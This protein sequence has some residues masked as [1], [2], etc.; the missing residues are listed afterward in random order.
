M[1]QKGFTSL[2]VILI[3]LVFLSASAFLLL[4]VPSKNKESIQSSPTQSETRKAE[5]PQIV[6]NSG[7]PPLKLKSIGINLDYYDP[8]TGKAG[9]FEFTK[10]KLE[11][12]RLFMG[13]GFVIPGNMSSTNQ[14][15]SNPQ[16]TFIL[17]LGT[18]VRSLVD[19]VVANIP[20]IWSGDVSIQI[21]TDGKLQKWVYETEHVINPKVKV[22]DKVKAGDIIAEVSNFDKGA[23]KGYGA[24]E[25]GILHGGGE[26]PPEHVCPFLYL[27]PSI[28]EET[29]KKITALFKSWEDY[30]GD[31][32]LYNETI[33]PG[34]LTQDPIDG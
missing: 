1:P 4:R 26:G 27:D 34:C 33:T 3:F 32:T 21:T 24:V 19:G 6:Q 8:K 20:A 25:I 29:L 12:N 22:G 23:P 31:Q 5:N 14:D 15:K 18:P 11:F 17:P 16:P 9:D 10:Q 13:Y 7:E 30:T 28:K 2:A